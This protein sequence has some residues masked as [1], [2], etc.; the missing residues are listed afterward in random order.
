M[1]MKKPCLGNLKQYNKCYNIICQLK[2]AFPS[3]FSNYYFP[4]F[5][6]CAVDNIHIPVISGIL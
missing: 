5:N 6:F 4:V 3:C 1:E 2:T